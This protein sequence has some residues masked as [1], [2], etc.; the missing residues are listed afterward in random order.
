MYWVGRYLM[1]LNVDKDP[2]RTRCARRSTDAPH[3]VPGAVGG[4]ALC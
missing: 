3:Y 2:G 1:C 4:L